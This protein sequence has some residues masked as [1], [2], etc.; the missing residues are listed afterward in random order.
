[1]G[2]NGGD[3]KIL[4][5]LGPLEPLP[6]PGLFPKP[7]LSSFESLG[8]VSPEARFSSSLFSASSP[9]DLRQVRLAKAL[10]LQFSTFLVLVALLKI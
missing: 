1:M 7:D 6:K 2:I 10:A 3:T 8:S 5:V 4:R 9:I